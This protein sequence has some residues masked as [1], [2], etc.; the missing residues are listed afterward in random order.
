MAHHLYTV[1]DM[2]QVPYMWKARGQA[3]ADAYDKVA[4][5]VRAG[6]PVTAQP[7]FETA[8]GATA[9]FAAAEENK[10]GYFSDG[11]VTNIFDDFIGLPYFDNQVNTFQTTTSNGNS[12][13]HAAYLSV[14]KQLSRGLLFQANYTFSHSLDTVG[15]T[16]E[17][18]FISPSDNFNPHRDYGASGFDRR[19]TL[20]LFYV[21]EL[22]FGKGHY[23][24]GGGN[25]ILDKIIGGWSF[26]GQFQAASGIPLT[27]INGN[28]GEEY[29]N[30]DSAGLGSGINSGM[31]PLAG[32]PTSSSTHYNADGSVTAFASPDPTLFRKLFFADQRNGTGAI[33]S[34]PR[35]NMDAALSKTV[36]ITERVKMGFGVQAVNVFNHME[37]ADPNLDISSADTF[38]TTTTQYTSP[39]FL[40]L[41]V[42]V[43]F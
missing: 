15:F 26:S 11:L 12:N 22:P 13:Y 19:H 29:G 6:Q 16:Q 2:N 21:Y 18:V 25:N 36:T 32:A 38:G 27:V 37:F 10:G 28:S 7:F 20:N 24:S 33:R 34:F 23:L 31:I 3:F 14:R 40:N 35:W 5:Q 4:A 1:N 8:P 42:R 30:G 9:A 41:N 39:R 17:N 43:D